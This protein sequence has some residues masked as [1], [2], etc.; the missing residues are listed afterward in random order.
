MV[1]IFPV[2]TI[3]KISSSLKQQL[4]RLQIKNH[5]I[6]RLESSRAAIRYSVLLHGI[7]TRGLSGPS[8]LD[9]WHCLGTVYSVQLRNSSL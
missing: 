4:F 6:P 8:L 2:T 9:G 1:V 7:S 5:T 3:N